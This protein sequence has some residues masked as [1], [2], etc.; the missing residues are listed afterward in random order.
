MH[1]RKLLV[2]AALIAAAS[3]AAGCNSVPSAVGNQ[4]AARL[5]AMLGPADHYEATV[6]GSIFDLARGKL[7]WVHIHGVNVALSPQMRAHDFTA[8]ATDIHADTR[9]QAIK[10]IGPT[11]FQVI[12]NQSD[13]DSYMRKARPDDY[14][15]GARILIGSNS[16]TYTS[17]VGFSL[18][19]ASFS[20][21][22]ALTPVKSTPADLNFEP[23]R[24]S[25]AHISV[26]EVLVRRAVAEVNPVVNL[27]KMTY[28]VA[29][30]TAHV[31]NGAL[32]ITGS[33]NLSSLVGTATGDPTKS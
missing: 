17:S 31:E 6:G 23:S 21:T 26:P 2:P 5:P 3:L 1:I 18:I 10:G 12:M 19:R 16:L 20:V 13:L 24:A 15:R 32:V 11:T 9:T 22:G 33:V 27:S 7:S 25:L 28:P 8:D 30:S 4:I 29:I 14:A